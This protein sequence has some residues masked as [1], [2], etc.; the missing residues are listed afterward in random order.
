M[1][2]LGLVQSPQ[3]QIYNKIPNLY[4]KMETSTNET[5]YFNRGCKAYAESITRTHCAYPCISSTYK[6]WDIS[7]KNIIQAEVSVFK[8]KFSIT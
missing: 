4:K 3:I 6:D 1:L 7:N 2:I 8:I 5:V